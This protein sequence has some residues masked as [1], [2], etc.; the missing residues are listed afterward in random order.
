MKFNQN[1]FELLR[2]GKQNDLKEAIKYHSPD[3]KE[4]EEKDHTRDLGIQMD[5][6]NTFIYQTE[7]VTKS[8]R[9]LIGWA[10]HVFT[11][12]SKTPMLILFKSLII[13]RIDYCSQ[14]W[15]PHRQN[16]MQCLE[17]LQRTFTSYIE[18]TKHENYWDRLRSL[19][20]FSIHRRF[21]RYAIIYV[22]KIMEG[23]VP[24]LTTHPIQTYINQRQER[25]SRI[26]PINTQ[27]PG[28]L[29]AIVEGSFHI[30]AARLFNA[31]PASIRN[32]SSVTVNTFKTKLDKVLWELPDQPSVPGYVGGRGTATNSLVD[33]FPA[34]DRE[35]RL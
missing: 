29:Q 33:V 1:K 18:E 22:W 5:N 23:L 31:L 13:P 8:C 6:G 21:E 14:L 32:V 34:M 20:L 7:S 16:E 35:R 4:I 28:Y 26:P 11:T 3:G 12:R 10:L 25:K 24:N 19:H 17:G 30:R 2:Y 27:C 15:A 9:K